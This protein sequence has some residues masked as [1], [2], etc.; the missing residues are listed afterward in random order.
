MKKQKIT[1]I[2]Y[3]VGNLSS[4]K[5]ALKFLGY[6]KILVSNKK[7]DIINSD[8]YIL[9]GVGA[10]QDAINNF[11]LN[12]LHDILGEEVLIKEKPILGICLGM[13]IMS[14]ISFEN[15]EN[16]GLG[17]IKGKVKLIDTKEFKVPHVGW[18]EVNFISESKL[19]KNI[20]NNSCFYFDHSY[21]FVCNNK[22]NSIGKVDYGNQITAVIRK[23]NIYGV[24]FHPEKSQNDGLKILRNFINILND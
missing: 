11:K 21:H 8:C 24:Q 22:S 18:N 6:S 17:W 3:G 23:K 2:D 13:Q 16:N 1:I 19:F 5:N 4:I 20:K 12:N 15:G 7:K 10:F 9:P 14:S